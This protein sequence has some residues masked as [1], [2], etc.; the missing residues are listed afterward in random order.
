MTTT[1]EHLYKALQTALE[2]L[3]L[4]SEEEMK[5][6]P[7]PNKWSKQEILGH[8]ID[9]A[10]NNLQ[11]FTEIQFQEKPYVIRPYSQEGLV[12]ANHYQT[13]HPKELITLWLSLNY[14][15]GHIMQQQTEATLAYA[16][17]LP[18]G[19]T[20]DLRFLMEDYVVHMEHH[21][22]QIINN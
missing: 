3:H 6:K 21:V 16:I 13:A 14:H 2:Y 1:T 12:N 10:V 7:Q 19:E 22:R 5:T 11:R 18:N 17:V 20:S 4:A 9:S 15:I 8:L